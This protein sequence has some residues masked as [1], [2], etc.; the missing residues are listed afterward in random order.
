MILGAELMTS[1]LI[2][3]QLAIIYPYD[4]PQFHHLFNTF[5]PLKVIDQLLRKLLTASPQT[6]PLL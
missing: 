3:K 5:I 1:S 4:H 6:A 2:T